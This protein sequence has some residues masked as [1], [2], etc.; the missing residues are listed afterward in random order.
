MSHNVAHLTARNCPRQTCLRNEFW[1]SV[2]PAVSAA[3]LDFFG[4]PVRFFTIQE[5]HRELSVNAVNVVQVHPTEAPAPWDQA[6][7]LVRNGRETWMID[8]YQFVFDSP[9]VRC[10]PALADYALPS[11][12]PGRPLLEAV[13]DL[14]R[15]IHSDFTFDP[16]ATTVA[17]PLTDVLSLRRGV[18]QDFAHLE[19]GCMRSLGLAARYVSGYLLTN[20]PPGQ[21]RLV[22]ADAS[23]AWLSVYCP[24]S[25]WVDIDPT[26]N[27]IPGNEHIVLSWGRDYDDVSPIKGVILGGGPHTLT[28]AVDVIR[29]NDPDGMTAQTQSSGG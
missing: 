28:V 19:I 25:G 9:Y 6:R 11:F 18:C 15:R 2:A 5:P 20:P 1:V 4:N 17:T 21:Q 22:G 24:W 26:N 3:Q 12:P 10:D 29:L 14:T 23:H 7:D 16:T 27:L 8:A 13:L